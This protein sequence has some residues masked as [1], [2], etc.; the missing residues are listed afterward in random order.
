MR[1]DGAVAPRRD[2]FGV[3][4][5]ALTMAQAVERCRAA[6]EQGDHLS[7]GVV[8]AAKIVAMRRD[9]QLRDAV[10]GC[11]MVLADG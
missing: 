10:A 5:D 1:S 9:R 2:L 3:A 8:N 7:I 6:V 11:E 4:I